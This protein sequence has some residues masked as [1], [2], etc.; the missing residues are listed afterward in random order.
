MTTWV[1]LRIKTTVQTPAIVALFD[2][3]EDSSV[4]SSE[5]GAIHK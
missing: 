5:T 1:R 4:A 3:G 2:C